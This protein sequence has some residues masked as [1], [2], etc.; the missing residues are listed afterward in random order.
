V[1][2][3]PSPSP[4]K[5]EGNVVRRFAPEGHQGNVVRRFAP[6]GL[7]GEGTCLEP[8]LHVGPLPEL[9]KLRRIRLAERAPEERIEVVRDFA[10]DLRVVLDVEIP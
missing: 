1:T 2:P 6:E 4:V 9:G 3:I 7:E 8:A 5:G 10:L